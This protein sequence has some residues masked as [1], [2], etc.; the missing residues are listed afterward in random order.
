M[1]PLYHIFGSEELSIISPGIAQRA[2]DPYVALN[3]ADAGELGLQNGDF[4]RFTLDRQNYQLPVKLDKALSRGTAGLPKGLPG[5]PYAEL[6]AW[7][8][9]LK[10]E[11]ETKPAWKNQAPI[12]S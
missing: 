1:V 9:I 8:I 5:V 12:I 7:A 3:S 11:P 6:P 10:T 4:L 2:P